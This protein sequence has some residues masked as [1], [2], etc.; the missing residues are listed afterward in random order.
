MKREG[1]LLIVEDNP[2]LA[3]AIERAGA[4]FHLEAD[5]A[6]DGWDAIEK[7]EHESY[8]T[9]VID[10]DIPRHSGYGVLAYLREENGGDL[11]NVILMS[12]DEAS[13]ERHLGGDKVRVIRRTETVEEL[14]K[15]IALTESQE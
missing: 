1:R 3:E 2:F 5:R 14:A 4:Q 8:S 13:V 10:A 9:I 6:S 7:L 11:P 15:A 12:A